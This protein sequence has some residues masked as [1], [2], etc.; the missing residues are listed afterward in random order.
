MNYQA[1]LFDFDY[2]LVNAEVGILICYHHVM[3]QH[4]YPRAGDQVV[5]D[6]I[7]MTVEGAFTF[8]T[9]VDDE[10]TLKQ[11]RKEYSALSDEVMIPNTQL[12]P[13]TMP[14]LRELKARGAKV[15]V[16]STRR[17]ERIDQMVKALHMEG[18][19]D[20]ILG[21]EDVTRHKP[22]PQ[23][24]LMALDKLGLPKEQV[25]YVG[26]HVVDGQAAQAAGVDFA[27]VAQGSTPKEKLEALPHVKVMDTLS[28]L[29]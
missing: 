4:G 28:E 25:L 22:D 11:W 27:G 8:L 16:V 5:K 17:R 29:L 21:G 3:E 9:G 15:G 1:Y 23:G 20:F 24:I 13:E 2:T 10:E 19:F 14:V 26:D 6:T 18:V 7:G 12:Y